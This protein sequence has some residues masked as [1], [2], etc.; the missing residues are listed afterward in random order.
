M[1]LAILVGVDMVYIGYEQHAFSFVF[2][3]S[4]KIPHARMTEETEEKVSD[5]NP[6][7]VY[8]H[9]VGLMVWVQ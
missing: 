5:V 9:E 1:V 7:P 6:E 8:W 3:G 4:W 2:W